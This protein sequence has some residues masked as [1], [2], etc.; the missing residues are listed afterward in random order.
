MNR[1]GKIR[2]INDS[3]KNIRRQEILYA[4]GKL[5]LKMNYRDITIKRIAEVTE[6]AKGTIFLYFQTK[7]DIF[8]SIAEQLIEEWGI[9]FREAV[10]TGIKPGKAGNVT[11][12]VHIVTTTLD[13]VLIVKLFAILDD[14]L[15]QNIE[16]KRAFEFKIFLKKILI[17][18]GSLIE[19]YFPKIKRG[20]G[21]ILLNGLFVCL[22]GAY[23]VSNQSETIK[24]ISKQPGMEIFRRDFGRILEHTT[25]C[26]VSG[27]LS[28]KSA[29]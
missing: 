26:Y 27:F 9:K 6:L 17:E 10:R 21:V 5:L 13:N 25:L 14:T 19:E 15:E 2:A 8:L 7:E 18:C 24:H 22:V 4:A 29:V 11:D 20:D 3:E 28:T 16:K 23:K 12:F 1:M